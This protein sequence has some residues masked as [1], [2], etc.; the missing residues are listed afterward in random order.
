MRSVTDNA[1]F[2]ANHVRRGGAWI[3]QRASVF[4]PYSFIIFLS[5]AC[6]LYPLFLSRPL[7]SFYLL[8][9]SFSHLFSLALSFSPSFLLSLSFFYSRSLS[10]EKSTFRRIE[11]DRVIV[12]AANWLWE[13]DA[14]SFEGRRG[15]LN[16]P[17]F[18]SKVLP[19]SQKRNSRF[20]AKV[21]SNAR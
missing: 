5:R 19:L 8:F 20:W 15:S 9:S 21:S 12:N 6:A 13:E 14:Q 1:N 3:S 16:L 7:S 10:E 18:V 4:V 2:V 11:S 17:P